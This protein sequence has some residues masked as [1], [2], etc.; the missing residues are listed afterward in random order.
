VIE[1]IRVSIELSL[2]DELESLS[3]LESIVVVVELES[4]VEVSVDMSSS[5]GVGGIEASIPSG[6]F[7]SSSGEQAMITKTN[8]EQ[9]NAIEVGFRTFES[10]KYRIS[11]VT[12]NR[13]AKIKILA[14]VLFIFLKSEISR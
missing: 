12:K 7:S 5:E 1:S 10:L 2:V 4:D 3:M 11:E 6:I 14:F 8:N 13:N 9:K